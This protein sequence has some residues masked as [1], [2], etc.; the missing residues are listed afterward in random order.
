MSDLNKKVRSGY[1]KIKIDFDTNPKNNNWV[2][3]DTLNINERKVDIN[4][5]DLFQ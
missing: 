4:Y 2:E 3:F 1:S 5:I